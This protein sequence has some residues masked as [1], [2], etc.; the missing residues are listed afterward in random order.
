MHSA[1]QSLAEG[2]QLNWMDHQADML[3]E[4]AKDSTG[5]LDRMLLFYRTG[6]GKTYS[7]LAALHLKGVTEVLVITPP[8]TF[9]AWQSAGV[10]FKINVSVMSHA[11]FRMADTKLSRTRA[12]IADEFHLFGGVKGEGFR[13]FRSATRHIKAPVILASA[14]P[15]YNDAERVYCIQSILDPKKDTGGFL[16]FLY[17]H[18]ET[19]QNP[20]SNTP[21]VTGFWKYESAAEFLAAMDQTFYLPDTVEY[22]IQDTSIEVD[23]PD[24]FYTWN[25]NPRSKRVMASIMER[26]HAFVNLAMIDD[27]GYLAESIYDELIDCAGVSDTLLIYANHSTV[28]EAAA[29]SMQRNGVTEFGL[30][31]GKT[32]PG[33]TNELLEQFRNGIIKYLIGT[34]SIA[35]GTDG[36]DKVCDH[37][38]LLDDTND[39]S[40]RR[41]VIGRI[42][43]RGLD[44]DAT[45]KMVSRIQLEGRP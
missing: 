24:E 14:T 32:T 1:V 3:D 45:N 19:E 34:D 10:L 28:A 7:A 23:I 33:R 40:R 27:D 38:V 5:K 8:A 25:Y 18:C 13:K 30:I 29:K 37:L 12:I 9:K 41:Q 35:T 4:V 11:K 6:A 20:F 22:E 42:M 16:Q 15:N 17:R 44:T 36:L 43:P 21:K 2:V 39:D 26:S 31:T